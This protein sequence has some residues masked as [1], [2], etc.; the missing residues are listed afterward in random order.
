M[1]HR[2][3]AVR[4]VDG[5][6]CVGFLDRKGQFYTNET[7]DEELLN[8]IQEEERQS[9]C[10]ERFASEFEEFCGKG[11]LFVRR[12]VCRH[13]L[14]RNELLLRGQVH[15]QGMRASHIVEERMEFSFF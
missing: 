13:V 4:F 12:P 14:V 2:R 10:F 11:L 3:C 15:D 5:W 7:C 6:C 1:H 9:K 8:K